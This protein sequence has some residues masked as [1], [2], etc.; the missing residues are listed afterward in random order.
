MVADQY[1][2]DAVIND[3]KKTLM[4]FAAD[5]AGADNLRKFCRIAHDSGPDQ[6]VWFDNLAIAA[7]RTFGEETV[8]YVRNI[9]KCSG[10][11]YKDTSVG[12]VV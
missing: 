11:N 4:A 5:N 6:N 2:N 1:L 7:A 8:E 10:P 3:Q 12:G 9:Y